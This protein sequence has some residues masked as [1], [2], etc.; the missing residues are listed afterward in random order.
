MS[1][2]AAIPFPEGELYC[3]GV[4]A[5]RAECRIFLGSGRWIDAVQHLQRPRPSTPQKPPRPG[6]P[7]KWLSIAQATERRFGV[8]VEVRPNVGTARSTAL[9]DKAWLEIR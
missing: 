9:A 6:S 8:P 5:N 4:K 2:I 1:F 3:Q 7:L